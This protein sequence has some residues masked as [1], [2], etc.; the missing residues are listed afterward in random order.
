MG[1]R[2]AEILLERI[3]QGKKRSETPFT[4]RLPAA[5]KTRESSTPPARNRSR[6]KP[7]RAHA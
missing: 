4:V 1:F 2:A 6:E 7:S 3:E 5:L